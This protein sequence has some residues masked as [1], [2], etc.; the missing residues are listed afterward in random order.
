MAVAMVAAMAIAAMAVDAAAVVVTSRLLRS[1]LR[2]RL[3]FPRSNFERH[4]PFGQKFAARC[5]CSPCSAGPAVKKIE[6]S[7]CV[8]SPI[9]LF[10]RR[11]LSGSQDGT[12]LVL[13]LTRPRS[14]GVAKMAT[15]S[16]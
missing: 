12:F 11:D 4:G 8:A 3:R 2:C 16:R 7:D 15:A 6:R 5:G 9:F 14:C 13:P 10:A 1:R